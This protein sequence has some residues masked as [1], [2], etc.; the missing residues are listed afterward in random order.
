MRRRQNAS[1]NASLTCW[2]AT[3]DKREDSVCIFLGS[4]YN[5][6]HDPE[7][8]CQM[9]P[10]NAKITKEIGNIYR[11]T[12]IKFLEWATSKDSA[13]RN[14]ACPETLRQSYG[15]NM[16]NEAGPAEAGDPMGFQILWTPPMDNPKLL[17][18]GLCAAN[19]GSGLDNIEC[20]EGKIPKTNIYIDSNH[21]FGQKLTNAFDQLAKLDLFENCV[22]LNL[23][24]FQYVGSVNKSYLPN[25]EEVRQFCEENTRKII[26]LIN[27]EVVLALGDIAH[28]KLKGF[29]LDNLEKI[30]HPSARGGNFEKHLGKFFQK[31]AEI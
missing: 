6:S 4:I 10:E 28:S 24:H 8:K 23:W 29:S 3:N 30:Q 27:P 26:E 16:P 13:Y 20:L 12:E 22:G 17:I 21:K 9:T 31:Y 2:G 18:C 15:K 7:K 1:L 11:E 19:F 5:A 14:A 25:S